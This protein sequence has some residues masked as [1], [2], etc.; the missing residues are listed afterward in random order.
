MQSK[1]KHFLWADLIR[2]F[3]IYLVL[4]IHESVLPQKISPAAILS[5]GAFS[6]AKTCVPLFVMLSG[7]L[8]LKKQESYQ[9][10]FKKRFSRI[11]AP[12]ITWTFITLFFVTGFSQ[13]NSFSGFINNFKSVFLSFWFLPMLVGLYLLTPPI[14]IFAKHA[15]IKGVWY[16]IFLWFLVVCLLPYINESPAF[17]LAVDNS[18]LRQVVE[19]L[20]YYLLG[21]ALVNT[22]VFKQKLSFSILL[23]VLGLAWSIV[24]VYTRSL[25]AG[26]ILDGYYYEYISPSI[27]LL[28]IGIFSA[29]YCISSKKEKKLNPI[30]RRCIQAVSSA[31]FG[32][33]LSHLVVK[34][35]LVNYFGNVQL[36]LY[37]GID[38][39]INGAVLFMVCFCLIFILQKIPLVKKIIA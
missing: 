23:I 7:A 17:P 10:F 26:G 37:P 33:Y 4:V 35:I 2:I 36:K 34:F 9:I 11:F 38:S 28:S 30:V 8:L 19:Y 1:T 27:A 29:I 16:V 25:H 22:T 6:I 15:H 3:A 21:Y 31:T 14:R 5:I 32:I 39:Y 24:G 20:G 18:L 12:W 13:I